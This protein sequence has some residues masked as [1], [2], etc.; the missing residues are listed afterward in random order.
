MQFITDVVIYILLT[1]LYRRLAIKCNL[2]SL[3]PS[4]LLKW[5]IPAMFILALLYTG[6]TTLKLYLFKSWFDP[7]FTQT[8]TGYFRQNAELIFVGGARL[9]S[10]WLLAYHLYHY[11]QREIIVSRENAKLE[12]ISR[13]TQL[14]N[15]SNQLNPHF[16][17]NSLNSIK[18][19]IDESPVSARRAVDLLSDVLR[20]G[21]YNGSAHLIPIEEE[22]DIVRDYL[23]LEKMR[24]E[25][26]L[27][28]KIESSGDLLN[29]SVPRLCI[30]TLTENAVKHGIAKRKGG[31]AIS[32]CVKS[33]AGNLEIAVQNSGVLDEQLQNIGLGLKNLRERLFLKYQGRA[34][35]SIVQET[36]GDVLTVINIPIT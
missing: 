21:L 2:I 27:C 25:E 6:V 16:L 3:S 12:L 8:Y 9:M 17:F 19:L 14:N 11:A 20:A 34:S 22:L 23:E 28:Y 32:V 36:P 18:A 29:V 26:R 1:D 5:V 10:I 4:G 33:K 30:Q 15:L 7:Q 13:E 35:F 24:F 31:G